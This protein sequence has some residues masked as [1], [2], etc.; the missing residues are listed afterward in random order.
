MEKYELVSFIPARGGSIRI[1]R[2]NIKMMAG[3]PMLAWT[4]E[5]SLK[6]KY[7]NRTFVST[8]DPEIK[9]IS[10]K[11]GAEVIDRPQQWAGDGPFEIYGFLQHFKDSLWEQKHFPDYLA[12]LPPTCP[13]RTAEQIDGAYELIL[14]KRVPMV[15]TATKWRKSDQAEEYFEK[16]KDGKWFKP[17]G[18]SSHR[19]RHIRNVTNAGTG[20][21]FNRYVETDNV[22]IT[23]FPEPFPPREYN[24]DVEFYIVSE[25]SSID[26]DTPLDFLIAESLLKERMKGEKGV[27]FSL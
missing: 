11:Y 19:R 26:V 16:D 1:P 27:F 8:E 25:A 15:R 5:A 23:C 22:A 10:L 6:S 3:K 21:V 7:V 18:W 24:R 20:T 13:L 9:E 4:I 2:K 14:E 12:F 17:M